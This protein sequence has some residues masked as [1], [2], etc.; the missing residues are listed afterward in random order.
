MLAE[1]QAYTREVLS[2]SRRLQIEACPRCGNAAYFRRHDVRPRNFWVIADRLVHRLASFVVRWTCRLCAHRLTDFPPFSLPHKRYVLSEV[3]ARSERYLEE[4]PATY[5]SSA[6]VEGLPVFHKATDDTIDDRR[7]ERS[8]VHRWV[9]FLGGLVAVLSS[10]QG[11]VR[12]A[13]PRSNLFR[14][15]VAFPPRKYRSDDRR[16]LLGRAARLLATAQ[17]FR[18]LFATSLF[19]DFATRRNLF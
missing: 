15:I 7:L 16:Q 18:R 17:E 19:P 14:S 3:V 2:G 10:A 4:D 9:T 12:R 8:T 13:D 11:L 5:E 6:G 1:V